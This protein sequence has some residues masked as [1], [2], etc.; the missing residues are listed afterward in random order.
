MFRVILDNVCA[1]HGVQVP[2]IDAR[3]QGLSRRDTGRAPRWELSVQAV[4]VGKRCASLGSGFGI[5]L[6]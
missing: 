2:H 1:G 5:G 4:S 3:T 6:T